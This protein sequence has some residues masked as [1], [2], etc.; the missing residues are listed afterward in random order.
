[1]TVTSNQLSVVSSSNRPE[2]RRRSGDSLGTSGSRRAGPV[3]CPPF[4]MKQS[5]LSNLG[6]RME[7]PPISWLMQLTL[8]SFICVHWRPFAVARRRFEQEDQWLSN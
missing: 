1:M 8:M 2:R 3:P 5:A 7:A 6:R 4:E